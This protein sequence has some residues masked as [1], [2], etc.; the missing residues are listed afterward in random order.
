MF[1]SQNFNRF[2]HALIREFYLKAPRCL[3][4]D[5]FGLIYVKGMGAD[6]FKQLLKIV[7]LDYP[8]DEMGIPISTTVIGNKDLTEHI[9]FIFYI[10]GMNGIE[11]EV[12]KQEWENLRKGVE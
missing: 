12:V 10:A 4:I 7:N 2:Y 11:L 1:I 6:N 8:R 5:G 3:K 9:E